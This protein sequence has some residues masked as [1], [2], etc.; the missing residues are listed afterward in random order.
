M[1]GASDDPR[2]VFV[3]VENGEV[4]GYAKLSSSPRPPSGRTTT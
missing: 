3:A 1:Q 2:A 4:L